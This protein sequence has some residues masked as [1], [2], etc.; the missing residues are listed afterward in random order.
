MDNEPIKGSSANAKFQ[1]DVL[2]V[3]TGYL[4]SGKLAR[5]PSDTFDLKDH[6]IHPSLEL[7][8]LSPTTGGHSVGVFTNSSIAAGDLLMECDIAFGTYK[9]HSTHQVAN[10]LQA[11]YKQGTPFFEFMSRLSPRGFDRPY[12]ETSP[13][14]RRTLLEKKISANQF[15]AKNSNF[16]EVLVDS[17]TFINHSCC[18]NVSHDLLQNPM[19]MIFWA[20]RPIA[21]GE[22]LTITYDSV[23]PIDCRTI[24]EERLSRILGKPCNCKACDSDIAP[25]NWFYGYQTNHCWWCGNDIGQAL[26]TCEECNFSMYCNAVCQSADYQVH[27]RICGRLSENT[28]QPHSSRA[29]HPRKLPRRTKSLWSDFQCIHTSTTSRDCVD[30]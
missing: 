20:L 22:E 17:G 18:P 23:C 25:S 21:A 5:A 15:Q 2:E 11:Y 16:S 28:R 7:R 1:F 6:W 19:R 3:G 10:A 30:A 26:P 8:C 13:D 24:R 12:E 29:V 14:D 9:G 27:S 4:V